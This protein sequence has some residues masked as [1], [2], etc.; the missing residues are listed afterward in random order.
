MSQHNYVR[1]M[2]G[3]NMENFTI[4]GVRNSTHQVKYWL[5]WRRFWRYVMKFAGVLSIKMERPQ[6]RV[7]VVM[8]MWIACVSN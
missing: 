8:N 5:L 6:E 3:T 4:Q 1:L 7:T 2:R